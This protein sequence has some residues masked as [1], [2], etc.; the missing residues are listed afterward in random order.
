MERI[1]EGRGDI[2]AEKVHR[3]CPTLALNNE[4]DT[5]EEILFSMWWTTIDQDLCVQNSILESI[6]KVSTQNSKLWDFIFADS[7]KAANSS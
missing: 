5:S 2:N 6:L 7:F 4:I 3:Q 1:Q